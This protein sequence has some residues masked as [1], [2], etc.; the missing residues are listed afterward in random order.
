MKRRQLIKHLQKHGCYVLR[1]GGGHT[2]YANPSNNA[3][4]PVPRHVEI[5]NVVAREIC[6]ELGI[7][8]IK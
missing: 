5:Q 4:A 6:K 3:S 2:I 1:E 7:P 8:T